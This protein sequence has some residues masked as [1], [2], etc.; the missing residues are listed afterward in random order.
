MSSLF[1][2]RLWGRRQEGGQF[3]LAVL[4]GFERLWKKKIKP[5]ESK[6]NSLSIHSASPFFPLPPSLMSENLSAFSSIN[7]RAGNLFSGWHPAD[8]VKHVHER[9]V[10]VPELDDDITLFAMK[11]F[12]SEQTHSSGLFCFSPVQGAALWSCPQCWSGRATD[13]SSNLHHI[14]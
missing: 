1:S 10:W 11:A 5:V 2:A 9:R 12:V 8:N 13:Q 6:W 4:S 3:W 14:A 7:K